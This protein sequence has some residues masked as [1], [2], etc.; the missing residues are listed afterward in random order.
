[1][2]SA[3]SQI[4]NP[5]S[6]ALTG[7]LTN[8]PR[9]TFAI[10]GGRNFTSSGTFTNQ[11]SIKV[12][13]GS[14]FTVPAGGTYM[15]TK[16]Q[17]V[18]DGKLTVATTDDLLISTDP[19]SEPASGTIKIA[20]GSV[21]GNG[22]NLAANVLSGGTITPADL[23][24]STGKLKITGNYN[25]VSAGALNANI[26]GA[27]SGQFNVLSVSGNASLAGTLNIKLLNNFVPLIG[28][29]FQILTARRV[30]GTF[31]NVTGTAINSDEHFTVTYN[32]NNVALE[33]VSGP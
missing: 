24:T 8:T 14:T 25:Q 17:T 16:G 10:S 19:D 29:T 23:P 1:M 18:V 6:D 20:K 5:S 31:A 12:G 4:L 3:T 27:N 30:E 33:V 22:G 21:F 13:K 2:T 26:T 9:G 11:G 15:Q 7:L 28:A 32:S